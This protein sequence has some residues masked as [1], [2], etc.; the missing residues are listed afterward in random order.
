MIA[1]QLSYCL[2][3]YLCKSGHLASLKIRVRIRPKHSTP[4][5]DDDEDVD[6]DKDKDKDN[7]DTDNTTTT[8]LRLLIL[9]QPFNL[10]PFGLS[11]THQIPILSLSEFVNRVEDTLGLGIVVW[12]LYGSAVAVAIAA[13]GMGG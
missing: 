6:T 7:S 8:H 1:P 5:S 9:D 12:C 4:D 2:A 10:L 13:V 3:Q 11:N